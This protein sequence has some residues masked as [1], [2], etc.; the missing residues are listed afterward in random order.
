MARTFFSAIAPLLWGLF[1][2]AAVAQEPIREPAPAVSPAGS[3]AVGNEWLLQETPP[4]PAINP[5]I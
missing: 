1:G 3:P 5:S 4:Q 2:S